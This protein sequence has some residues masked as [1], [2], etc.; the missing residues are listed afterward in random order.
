ME[1]SMP[2]SILAINPDALKYGA[3]GLAFIGVLLGAYVVFGSRSSGRPVQFRVFITFL[4]FVL[5]LVAMA[6]GAEIYKN[7]NDTA[8]A[9]AVSERD[10]AAMQAANAAADL[11]A[12]AAAKAKADADLAAVV[13]GTKEQIA[14][15]VANI[16]GKWC[17]E[18][19][20]LQAGDPIREQS[21][22]FLTR[23]R[24]SIARMQSTIGVDAA[25][26]VK[27]TPDCNPPN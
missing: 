4:V 12:L 26:Q 1:A 9:Q 23:M 13:S 18:L 8:L 5:A 11:Q 21:I 6:V 24:A 16:D 22:V 7:R 27:I 20:A 14:A 3:L 19:L 10:A 15:I 25:D 2:D 17:A